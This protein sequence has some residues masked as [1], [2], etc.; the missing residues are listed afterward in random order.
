MGAI[1]MNFCSR[2]H[3]YHHFFHAIEEDGEVETRLT[4][5]M[6]I[7]LYAGLVVISS[8]FMLTAILMSL[9]NMVSVSLITSQQAQHYA[10]DS[11]FAIKLPFL[12]L[13]YGVFMWHVALGV[14]MIFMVSLH[15]GIFFC[16]T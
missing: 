3:N 15:F 14:L 12:A 2:L 1:T 13:V 4:F 9:I 5:D 8:F 6:E 7:L 10:Q 11:K 16:V